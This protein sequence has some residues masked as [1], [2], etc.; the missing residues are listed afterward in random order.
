M[1]KSWSLNLYSVIIEVELNLKN[2]DSKILRKL[3]SKYAAGT[4]AH[5]HGCQR[6]ICISKS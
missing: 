5:K 2:S 1:K 3:N 4:L 6:V